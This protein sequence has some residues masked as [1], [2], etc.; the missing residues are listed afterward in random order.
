L[1]I[2]LRSRKS[3]LGHWALSIGLVAAGATL[4]HAADDFQPWTGTLKY[5]RAISINS[6]DATGSLNYTLT[7]T[8]VGDASPN[9]LLSGKLNASYA[10][11]AS[12]NLVIAS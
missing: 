4:A 1:P 3:Y 7:I 8:F 12:G 9:G 2:D 6:K 10:F 11:D 5:H